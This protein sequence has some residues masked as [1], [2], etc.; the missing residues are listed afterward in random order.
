MLCHLCG[1][2]GKH[3][4]LKV[5]ILRLWSNHNTGRVFSGYTGLSIGGMLVLQNFVIV[6]FQKIMTLCQGL[7]IHMIHTVYSE[8]N[9]SRPRMRQNHTELGGNPLQQVL[10]SVQLCLVMGGNLIPPKVGRNFE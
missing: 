2:T 7:N 3:S 6:R 8:K 10:Y 9:S 1:F 5:L 4:L